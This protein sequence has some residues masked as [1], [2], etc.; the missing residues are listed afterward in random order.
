ME[1]NGA[2]W[3]PLESDKTSLARLYRLVRALRRQEVVSVREPLRSR[4]ELIGA[5]A[6]GIVRGTDRPLRVADVCSEL[7]AQGRDVNTASV[8]KALHDRSR[9]PAPRLQRVG[10]GLYTASVG[11]DQG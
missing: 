6:E 3:N 2:L 9:G 7:R 10:H 4:R 11:P 5:A 8:R 1:L